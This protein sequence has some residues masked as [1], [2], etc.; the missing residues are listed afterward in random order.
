MIS[1]KEYDMRNIFLEKS[2]TKF[3]RDTLPDSLQKIKI[4]DISGSIVIY[5]F[6]QFVFIVCQIEDFRS[7]LKLSCRSLACT[8]YKVFL[9]K[10]KEVG[11]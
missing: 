6:I 9:R 1:L 11:N 5:S 8:S 7:I 4:D 2:Y 3:G 10:Q